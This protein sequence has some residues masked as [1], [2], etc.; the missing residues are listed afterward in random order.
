MTKSYLS[1]LAT[2]A[3]LAGASVAGDAFSQEDAGTSQERSKRSG[4][5]RGSGRGFGDPAMMIERMADHLQLDDTQR[6]SIAN[7]VAASKPEFTALREAAREN[8][9]AIHGLDV[10][11]PDYGSALQNLSVKSGELAAELTLLTGRLRGEIADVLTAEQ[12]ELLEDRMS[13]MGDR[14]RHSGRDQAR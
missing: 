2:L 4:E 14:R 6:Q 8:R 11:D 3:L 9:E 1:V 5:H 12:R 7:I 13:R 10:D